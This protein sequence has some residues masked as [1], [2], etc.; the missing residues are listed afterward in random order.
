LWEAQSE[1][2][3]SHADDSLDWPPMELRERGMRYHTELIEAIERG[4]APRAEALMKE[5]DAHPMNFGPFVGVRP[6]EASE[7]RFT[8]RLD[9][10]RGNGPDGNQPAVA[11]P[12]PRE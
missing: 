12:R 7:R 2:W 10:A 1:A 5:L 4:D 9:S 6:L 3:F 11:L 8:G